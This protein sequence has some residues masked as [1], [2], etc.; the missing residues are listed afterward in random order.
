MWKTNEGSKFGSFLSNRHHEHLCITV[1]IT[2]GWGDAKIVVSE[3][4][5]IKWMQ[6][7]CLFACQFRGCWM[8]VSV[9]NTFH[10]QTCLLFLYLWTNRLVTF[11][12]KHC[13]QWWDAGWTYLNLS[14][15]IWIHLQPTCNQVYLSINQCICEHHHLKNNMKKD[16]QEL[17][18]WRQM[19]KGIFLLQQQPLFDFFFVFT[20]YYDCVK[21]MVP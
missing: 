6:H 13:L 14:E 9:L 17:Y 7:I 3:F 20:S 19:T 2:V 11:M 10:C 1:S 8:L 5:R 15:I 16:Y 4:A 18:K 12:Y 21:Y